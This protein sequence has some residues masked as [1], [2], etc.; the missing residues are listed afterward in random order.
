MEREPKRVR[1]PEK[2]QRAGKPDSLPSLESL[3]VT[4]ELIIPPVKS[5]GRSGCGM[6][7]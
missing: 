1:L 4:N 6:C 7:G 2:W 5:A 3:G